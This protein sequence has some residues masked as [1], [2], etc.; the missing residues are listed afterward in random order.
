MQPL[1]M[2]YQQCPIYQQGIG[3]Q[4]FILSCTLVTKALSPYASVVAYSFNSFLSAQ[5]HG[6][7]C[8]MTVYTAHEHT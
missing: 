8:C 7:E 4:E 1:A 2:L 6:L 5:L 3:K